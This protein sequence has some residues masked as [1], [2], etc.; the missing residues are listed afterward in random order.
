[1]AIRVIIEAV[2][3]PIAGRRIVVAPGTILRLGR[4]TK[5]DYAIPEDGYLSG[6]H[7][8]IE[9][10]GNQCRVR[11]LGSSNGTF[12]NGTRIGDAIVT[13]ADTVVA[14]G[15]TFSVRFEDAPQAVDLSRTMMGASVPT[16]TYPGMV[17][18]QPVPATPPSIPPPPQQT[19]SQP[20]AAQEEWP[21]YSAQHVKLLGSIYQDSWPVYAVLDASR[22]SRVPAFLDASREQYA[23]L[24]DGVQAQELGR[25]ATYLVLL[26][27][28]ARL[29]DVLIKDGWGKG[30]G[31]YLTTVAPLDELRRHLQS[32]YLM[33]TGAGRPFSFRFADPRILRAFL[34]LASPQEVTD[35]FGP[36]S[37][38]IVEGETPEMAV[39]LR[40]SGRG[41]QQDSVVLL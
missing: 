24:Y 17:P 12:V 40:D 34:P 16:Q 10:D 5:S 4:T 19:G 32:F 11:D 9:C 2:A 3:G 21:G 13:P 23:S 38:I 1:M 6:Q 14:G 29:L 27:P 41:L 31:F 7:F 37:R 36:M 18:T 33:R 25:T 30:W 28:H 8:A 26:P 22:E 39:E 20:V 15:S 35:F